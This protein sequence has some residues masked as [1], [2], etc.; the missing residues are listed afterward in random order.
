VQAPDLLRIIRNETAEI[1]ILGM[2]RLPRVRE[3]V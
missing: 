2:R 1:I 3:D